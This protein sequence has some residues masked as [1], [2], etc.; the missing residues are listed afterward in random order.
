MTTINEYLNRNV[1]DQPKPIKSLE[2][3]K[4]AYPE[5]KTWVDADDEDAII[6]AIDEEL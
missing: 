5:I 2:E 6:E 1:K 4:D 3:A